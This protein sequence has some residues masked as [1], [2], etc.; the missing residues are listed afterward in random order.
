[1]SIEINKTYCDESNSRRLV[2]EIDDGDV[3]FFT[4]ADQRRGR[5]TVA[6]FEAWSVGEYAN[7]FA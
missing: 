1:M 6:E 2:I 7:P 3:L 5:C 4:P